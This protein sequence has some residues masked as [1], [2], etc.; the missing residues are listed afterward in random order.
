MM[1]M[2]NPSIQRHEKDKE[3]PLHRVIL[4]V[5]KII[6]IEGASMHIGTIFFGNLKFSTLYHYV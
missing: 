6:L 5:R 2:L 3:S 1:L 4:S